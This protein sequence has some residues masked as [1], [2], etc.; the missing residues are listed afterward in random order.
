[1]RLTIRTHLAIR[2]LTACAVNPGRVLRKHELAEAFCASGNHLAQ[3]INTLGRLGYLQTVRG[4]KGGMRLARAPEQIRIGAVARAFEA[5]T[6]LGFCIDHAKTCCPMVRHCRLR[7][8]LK[9]AVEAFYGVL[10]QYSLA[11]MIRDNDGLVQFLDF[12]EPIVALSTP[13]TH[14]GIFAAAN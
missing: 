9:A 5:G 4:R 7:G 1:M 13:C 10:D 12:D 11:D 6:A 14:S 2:T 3:V 8:A